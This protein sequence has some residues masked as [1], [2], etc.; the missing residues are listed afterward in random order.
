[1]PREILYI[2]EG[3]ET[4]LLVLVPARAG[5]C[6]W[7]NK[8]KEM[9]YVKGTDVLGASAKWLSCV[10]V[11]CV[12]RRTSTT[13]L[14]QRTRELWLAEGDELS[15]AGVILTDLH[16]QASPIPG[17]D[18]TRHSLKAVRARRQQRLPDRPSWH[19]S[20][21]S[22]LQMVLLPTYTPQRGRGFGR[23]SPSK[24]RSAGGD[25]SDLSED[26]GGVSTIFASPHYVPSPAGWS[27]RD[28]RRREC[29]WSSG[30]A[31]PDVSSEWAVGPHIVAEGI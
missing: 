15:G 28:G 31:L 7:T 8:G 16:R 22:H 10:A 19:Q 12:L 21:Q 26:S 6:N 13:G 25:T 24:L 2:K 20:L 3:D 30:V 11:G 18:L 1:M 27:K 17:V 23:W 9:Q 14:R 4:G 29:G 5:C